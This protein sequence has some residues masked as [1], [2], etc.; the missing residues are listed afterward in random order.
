MPI[1]RR[2]FKEVEGVY[3][4]RP[5][6]ECLLLAVHDDDAGRRRVDLVFLDQDIVTVENRLGI[7]DAV[8][9]P[10]FL[11]QPLDPLLRRNLLV[12]G[13]VL[14]DVPDPESVLQRIVLLDSVKKIPGVERRVLVE[15]YVHQESI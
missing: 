3:D 12:G 7:P 1:Y 9:D 10:F 14:E 5:P 8:G 13:S 11:E 15:G 2:A 4:V 6:Y